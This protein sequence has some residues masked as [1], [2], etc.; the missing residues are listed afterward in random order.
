MCLKLVKHLDNL[1]RLPIN[2]TVFTN[3]VEKNKKL[4]EEENKK[5]EIEDAGKYIYSEFEK[6]QKE[7]HRLENPIKIDPASGLP[8]CAFH[9]DRVEHFY[10]KSH[11]VLILLSR[12]PGAVFASK[13]ATPGLIA[14]CWTCTQSMI[15]MST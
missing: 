10:C 5:P 4:C 1:D 2:H 9:P 12:A 6:V 3:L 15:P 14:K 11:K 8:F 13:L 7:A